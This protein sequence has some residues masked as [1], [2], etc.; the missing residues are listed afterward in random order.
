MYSAVNVIFVMLFLCPMFCFFF[1]SKLHKPHV[2]VLIL[3]A[4]G[5]RLI[6]F[7]GHIMLKLKAMK[8]IA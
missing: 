8:A 5:K 7:H 1:P 3:N 4:S 2:S 6:S